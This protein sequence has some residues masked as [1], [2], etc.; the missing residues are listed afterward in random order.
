MKIRTGKSGNLNHHLSL[1]GNSTVDSVWTIKILQ[2]IMMNIIIGVI[3]I[4][5][6]DM[7]KIIKNS[8]SSIIVVKKNYFFSYGRT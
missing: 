2:S 4:M 6:V 3:N 8:V 7:L 1:E 5:K